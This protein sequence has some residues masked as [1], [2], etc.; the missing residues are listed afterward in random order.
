MIFRLQ[1]FYQNLMYYTVFPEGSLLLNQSGYL[2]T[3]HS[4]VMQECNGDWRR[5]RE[6]LPEPQPHRIADAFL[7]I[8]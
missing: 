6:K 5:N 2:E 1:L 4:L 8:K 3:G 7:D